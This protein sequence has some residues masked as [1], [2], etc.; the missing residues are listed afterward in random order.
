[1]GETAEDAGSIPAISIEEGGMKELKELGINLIEADKE[2]KAAIQRF[3]DASDALRKAMRE[4]GQYSIV[5]DDKLLLWK[6]GIIEV[7]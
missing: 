5:I 3:L 1:M 7:K 4:K 6:N 2:Y